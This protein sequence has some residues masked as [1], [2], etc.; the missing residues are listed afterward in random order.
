MLRVAGNNSK[1]VRFKLSQSSYG[2]LSLDDFIHKVSV[3]HEENFIFEFNEEFQQTV[4]DQI[5]K[6]I[7]KYLNEKEQL[8]FKLVIYSNKSILDVQRILKFNSWHVTRLHIKRIIRIVKIYYTYEQIDQVQLQKELK[9]KFNKTERQI[10]HL[11]HE[12]KTIHQIKDSM[13][14]YY[15]KAYY[16]IINVLKKL[17]DCEGVCAEY[18]TFLVSIRRFKNM[19]DF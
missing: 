5:E 15:K 1:E 3:E 14:Y 19:Q 4:A 18:H 9:K 7:V 13:G 8:M 11:L 17:E 16:S 2:S 12:R 6:I 10:I